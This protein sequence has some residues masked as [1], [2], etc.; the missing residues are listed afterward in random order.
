MSRK[1]KMLPFKKQDAA[2][3]D[4]REMSD[5]EA[6]DAIRMLACNIHNDFEF[7]RV[8]KD[9]DPQLREQVYEQIKPFVGYDCPRPFALMSFE[10]DA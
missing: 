3:A 1:A 6:V 2:P 9:A 5:V 8:L 4:D 7:I 10:A